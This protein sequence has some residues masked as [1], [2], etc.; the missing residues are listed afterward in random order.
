MTDS[1]DPAGD[2]WEIRQLV[3]RYASAADRADGDAVAALF[4]EDGVLE[5]R[6]DPKTPD[7]VTGVRNG[8]AEIAAAINGISHYRATQHLIANSVAELDGD[9]A[10]GVTHCSAHHL[11][12]ESDGNPDRVLFIR[13]L[14]TFRRPDGRWRISRRELRVQ[15]ISRQPVE[16][17]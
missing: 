12:G 9:R 5:V 3:E 13:Y 7:Q 10:T 1:L 6:L 2:H 16:S 15:W 14:D 4:T 8:H 11:G 17:P